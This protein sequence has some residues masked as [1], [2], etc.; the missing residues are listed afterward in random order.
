M[1]NFYHKFIPNAAGI[2][3]PLYK[4]LQ[5]NQ[6]FQWSQKCK[7]SFNKIKEMLMTKSVLIHFDSKIPI[8]LTTDAAQ[9]GIGAVL[10]HIIEKE[11]RPIAYASRVLTKSEINYSQIE[12]V[13]LA[14]KFGVEKF[15]Q[16]LFGHSFT[17]E[18]DM[19]AL[20]TIFGP[21]KGLPAMAVGRLQ[22]WASFLSGFD[23]KIKYVKTNENAVDW[24]SRSATDK[25]DVT[26]V[27][28]N[29]YCNQNFITSSITNLN[30]EQMKKTK[31]CETLRQVSFYIK[32]GWPNKNYSKE[33]I[34]YFNRKNELSC[35]ND[36]IF[37]DIN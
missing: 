19:K 18:T 14:I 31:E 24:L 6:K 25:N 2:L 28:Q 11:T 13:A 29:Y 12:K 22:R 27:E 5:K 33:L 20:L 4:L 1:V 26:A 3:H 17:L 9:G 23:F 7:E 37:M 10:S 21:K 32:L 16:Y 8:K 15:Y 34:L 35:E 30:V 36:C